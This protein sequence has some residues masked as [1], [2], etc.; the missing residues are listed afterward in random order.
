M[1][2]LF[3]PNAGFP[4]HPCCHTFLIIAIARGPKMRLAMR[5]IRLLARTPAGSQDKAK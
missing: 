5:F 3:P 1:A 4:L 2:I